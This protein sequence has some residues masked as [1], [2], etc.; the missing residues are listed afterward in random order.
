MPRSVMKR[1]LEALNSRQDFDKSQHFFEDDCFQISIEP[2]KHPLVIT[3][4][5]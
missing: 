3:I 1:L 4:H 2:G 5:Y